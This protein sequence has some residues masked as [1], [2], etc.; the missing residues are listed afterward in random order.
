MYPVFKMCSSFF[1]RLWILLQTSERKS[2]DQHEEILQ[3]RLWWVELNP[4]YST[5]YNPTVEAHAASWA[6]VD[7]GTQLAQ[8]A[9]YIFIYNTQHQ[10]QASRRTTLQLLGILV[11]AYSGLSRKKVKGS[12]KGGGQAIREKSLGCE[13]REGAKGRGVSGWWTAQQVFKGKADNR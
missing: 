10:A 9:S 1:S 6:P 5:V 2:E 7:L 3:E 12:N 11:T 13:D 4:L 8:V